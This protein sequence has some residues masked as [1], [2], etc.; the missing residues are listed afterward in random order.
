MN[1][2]ILTGRFGLGH[3]KA[4]EAIKEQIL[5]ENPES[6]VE[7]IDFMDY[8][9][10]AISKCIYKG[11]NFLVA[12]CSGLYNA[13]NK[14]AGDTNMIPLKLTVTKKIDRLIMDYQPDRIVVAFPVCS[15]YISAYKRMRRCAVPLYTYITDITAHEEWIAPATDRYFVGDIT[16]KN[17]L[18]SKGVPAD[19]ITVSGI[20]VLQRFQQR[21]SERQRGRTFGRK[22]QI[23]VMGGGLGL[24]PSS[25]DFLQILNEQED[26]ETTVICGHNK[27]LLD[28]IQIE[29]PFIHAVGYTDHVEQYMKEADLLVTK[30]GGLTTFEA[31][32]ACT[33]LYIIHP[34]LE[35]EFGNASYIENH[36][37]GR[38]L[39]DTH[40]DEGEDILRLL[41]DEKLLHQMSR[42]MEMLKTTFEPCEFFE[43]EGEKRCS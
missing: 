8:M 5:T 12:R 9:F 31:V 21:V 23:L 24:L 39:W 14:A 15:Q 27:K 11:F 35:Q 10:P 19:R 18:Q 34:F 1:I 13:M 43:G 37:I 40:I 17:A 2:M 22:K 29:Y 36:N 26:V 28:T 6:N 4:A 30:A 32:A 41:R 7:I 38:V 20:P 42:N 16:T 3:V 33:P 25:K